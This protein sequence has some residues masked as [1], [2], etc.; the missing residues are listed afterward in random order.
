MQRDYCLFLSKYTFKSAHSKQICKISTL[1]SIS[2]TCWS[3]QDNL[4]FPCSFV[5]DSYTDLC[6][7]QKLQ[8]W[9]SN[10]A[11]VSRKWKLC[12]WGGSFQDLLVQFSI[13]ICSLLLWNCL[14]YMI[15]PRDNWLVISPHSPIRSTLESLSRGN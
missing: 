13:S 2:L 10:T 4:F 8:Q 15:S 1:N 12:W 7:P 14:G 6:C 5:S 9:Q 3:T 11:I